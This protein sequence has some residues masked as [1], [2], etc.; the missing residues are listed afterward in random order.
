MVLQHVFDEPCCYYCL[1]GNFLYLKDATGQVHEKW[2][3]VLREE[4]TII[5]QQ[6]LR[7]S[8]T[9]NIAQEILLQENKSLNVSFLLTEPHKFRGSDYSLTK[10]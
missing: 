2:S 10:V 9:I 4:E 3:I 1:I 7:F 6:F 5:L 8:E